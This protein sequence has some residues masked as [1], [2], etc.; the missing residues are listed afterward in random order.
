MP[1]SNCYSLL[2]AG[3]PLPP[4]PLPPPFF[5]FFCRHF[6][7][8]LHSQ[9]YS[10]H[11]KMVFAAGCSP[12]ACCYGPFAAPFLSY[13]SPN[14]TRLQENDSADPIRLQLIVGARLKPRSNTSPAMAGQRAGRPPSTGWSL[15]FLNS[16][17]Q[18][19]FYFSVCQP[20]EYFEYTA[21]NENRSAA[22]RQHPNNGGVLCRRWAA[23]T[24]GWRRAA[25]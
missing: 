10:L 8:L 16:I 17:F 13:Y 2:A 9:H 19:L 3:A 4:P 12:R 18:F 20:T 24:R 1:F 15:Y 5:F 23:C 14:V 11:V 21:I 25:G 22:K 6:A 7:I